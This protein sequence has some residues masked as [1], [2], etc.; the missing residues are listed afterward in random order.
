MRRQQ[1]RPRIIT[2][3]YFNLPQVVIHSLAMWGLLA[4]V[5]GIV[6]VMVCAVKQGAFKRGKSGKKCGKKCGKPKNDTE[7]GAENG[8]ENQ[9]AETNVQ[10]RAEI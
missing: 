3:S 1:R 10:E 9:N 7:N 4:I 2:V 6:I 8:V 5:P